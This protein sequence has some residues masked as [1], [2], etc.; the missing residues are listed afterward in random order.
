MVELTPQQKAKWELLA[1]IGLEADQVMHSDLFYQTVVQAELDAIKQMV[2]TDPNDS[3]GRDR[4]HTE[5]HCYRAIRKRLTSKRDKGKSAQDN[6]DA[7]EE[8]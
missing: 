1:T 7:L 6:L 4:Y 8:G 3:A 2:G 5:I